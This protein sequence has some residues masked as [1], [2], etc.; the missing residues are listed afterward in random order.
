MDYNEPYVTLKLSGLNYDTPAYDLPQDVWSAGQNVRFNNGAT[1][2]FLGEE[3]VFGTLASNTKPNWM[4]Q[5]RYPA[6]DYWV[7]G[8]EDKV[9]VL[10]AST[11]VH[12]DITPVA[13]VTGDLD[14]NWNGCL[15]NNI[16][17][18]NNG[19]DA[20]IWWN[21]SP[22]SVMTDL[23]AWPA[24]QKA[25]VIRS[26]KNYLIA[27]NI[28]IGATNYPDMVH[29]SDSA[30]TG[31]IPS[32][33]D[34][35]DTTKDAGKY[36]L[37]DTPGAVIDGAPL[38]DSF[39]VYKN[40]SCHTLQYVGGQFIFKIRKLHGDVGILAANCVQ[41]FDGKH[42]LLTPDDLVIIDGSGAK[43]QS[44]LDSRMR[45]WLF[46]YMDDVNYV[47]SFIAH[48]PAR[49]E[50]WVC[51]PSGGSSY[52]DTAVV[53]NYED[54]KIGTRAVPSAR[55]IADG[56]VDPGDT[57]LWD[58]DSEAWDDDHLLWHELEYSGISK[59]LL[60]GDQGNSKFLIADKNYTFNGTEFT[61][62]VERESIPI[63]ERRSLQLLKG[64]YPRFTADGNPTVQIRIG[65]QIHPTDPIAWGPDQDFVIGVDDKIDIL[66][67][68]RYISIRCGSTGD[69]NWQL[70]SFDLDVEKAE[71]W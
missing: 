50:M 61:S 40:N 11:S 30:P 62:Y 25:E 29:W 22:A 66:A 54:N 15:I 1:E 24:T 9:A 64:V 5:V 60:I 39:V 57:G 58:G 46:R 23:T 3:Q 36:D 6:E 31:S 13:G 59:T 34:E 52:A 47:R 14:T 20:P 32:S 49:R 51:F 37:A 41:E 42:L 65:T 67:K 33:W 43:P 16:V 69:H 26:Y 71:R 12:T 19:S 38:G 56:I 45:T 10:A 7:Y 35:T 21:G 70:H 68:G 55:F 17:V 8:D 2:R 27:M 53:W 48:H 44:I 18:M 4:I 28:T 63:L